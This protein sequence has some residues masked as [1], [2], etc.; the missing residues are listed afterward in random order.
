MRQRYHHPRSRRRSITALRHVKESLKPAINDSGLVYLVEWY[1]DQEALSN[2]LRPMTGFSSHNH[3]N[4]VHENRY[5]CNRLCVDLGW[6]L[7]NYG[8]RVCFRSYYQTHTARRLFLCFIATNSS[9][10]RPNSTGRVDV[11]LCTRTS[12]H[13]R[14]SSR[15]SN[16]STP[17]GSL[18]KSPRPSLSSGPILV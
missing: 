6:R 15:P 9:R 7:Q 1:S 2:Y 18:S 17:L 13:R 4:N 3:E 11:V 16:Q 14:R 10:P 12:R 5:S 8:G